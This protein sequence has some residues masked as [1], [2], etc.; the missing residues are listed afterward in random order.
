M[1]VHAHTYNTC[2]YVYACIYTQYVYCSFF[3][4]YT[5]QGGFSPAGT[6]HSRVHGS[7]ARTSDRRNL[8]HGLPGSIEQFR[9][10]GMQSCVHLTHPFG[11]AGGAFAA[12]GAFCAEGGA[13]A[14]RARQAGLPRGGVR[15]CGAAGISRSLQHHRTILTSGNLHVCICMYF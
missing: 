3:G 4:Q 13:V 12:G 14:W 2:I 11:Q 15:G 1:H 8:K 5:N 10:L 9:V 6:R 7:Q